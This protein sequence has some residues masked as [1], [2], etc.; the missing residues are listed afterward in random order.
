MDNDNYI[1]VAKCLIFDSN[2]KLLVLVR[3]DSHPH[4]GG[5]LDFP[6]GKVESGEKLSVA[7]AGEA[8]EEAGIK[9][10]I[11]SLHHVIEGTIH[12]YHDTNYWHH[13]YTATTDEVERVTQLSWEH[14]DYWWLTVDELLDKPIPDGVDPY[15]MLAL[16]YL[17]SL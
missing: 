2:G 16:E 15:Y 3:G 12:D 7:A 5:H 4:F 13:V 14:K 9:L 8:D 6:G 17:K 1:H 10:S 11:D